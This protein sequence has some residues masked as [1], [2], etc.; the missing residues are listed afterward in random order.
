MSPEAVDQLP[1]ILQGNDDPD[2]R[3]GQFLSERRVSERYV[4]SLRETGGFLSTNPG[5]AAPR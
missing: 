4:D 3:V 1:T 2:A 5:G